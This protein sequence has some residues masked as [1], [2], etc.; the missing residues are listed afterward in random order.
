MTIGNTFTLESEDCMGDKLLYVFNL[1]NC[2]YMC[3][4]SPLCLRFVFGSR[5]L[6][7]HFKNL[8]AVVR[9]IQLFTEY[10]EGKWNAVEVIDDDIESC[11]I[12]I[13]E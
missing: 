13:K 4:T 2:M 6:V 5:N 12:E 10:L 8:E 1:K 3:R 9:Y 11:E 7:V